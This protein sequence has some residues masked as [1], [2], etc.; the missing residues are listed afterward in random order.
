MMM[1]LW[2]SW[3]LR[4]RTLLMR[5]DSISRKRYI[6]HIDGSLEGLGGPAPPLRAFVI[7]A[8]RQHLK[9]NR[10][11]VESLE[12]TLLCLALARFPATCSARR[13]PFSPAF[14]NAGRPAGKLTG[15]PARQAAVK[16]RPSRRANCPT[17]QNEWPPWPLLPLLYKL[18]IAS[19]TSFPALEPHKSQQHS[20]DGHDKQAARVTA[21]SGALSQLTYPKSSNPV[22]AAPLLLLLPMSCVSLPSCDDL[23]LSV[24]CYRYATLCVFQPH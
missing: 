8:A 23:Y 17:G 19:I 1:R 6:K 12:T 4:R 20:P 22:M 15:Q 9:C 7:Y 2:S 10:C 5:C 18:A 13:T 16:S 14:D 21:S 24:A 11:Q 3:R